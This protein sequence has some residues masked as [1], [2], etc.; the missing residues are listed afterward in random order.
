MYE[1]TETTRGRC[2]PLELELQEVVCHSAP[3]L[4]IEFGSSERAACTLNHGVIFPATVILITL[5]YSEVNNLQI[6][7]S[8]IFHKLMTHDELLVLSESIFSLFLIN[9]YFFLSNFNELIC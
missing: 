9:F 8:F 5:N 1:C 6:I 4:G 7:L 2:T 3:V